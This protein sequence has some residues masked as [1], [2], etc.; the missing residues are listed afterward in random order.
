[1]RNLTESCHPVN[2][3]VA[4]LER[5]IDE[6]I[7]IALGRGVA[8]ELVADNAE[9]LPLS[10]RQIRGLCKSGVLPGSKRGRRWYVKRAAIEAYLSPAS[11]PAPAND[12][13]TSDPIADLGRS[14]GLKIGGAR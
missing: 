11:R 4:A 5:L 3:L 13:K 8:D 2:P 9:G 10:S 12:E 14:L 1:M 6:R 7:R